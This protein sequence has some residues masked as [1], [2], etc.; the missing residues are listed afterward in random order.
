MEAK[1]ASNREVALL[2]SKGWF[3]SLTTLSC[4]F[5]GSTLGKLLAK[6]TTTTLGPGTAAADTVKQSQKVVPKKRSGGGG[7]WRAFCRHRANGQKF[8]AHLLGQFG[9]EWRALGPQ[10]RAFYEQVGQAAT[11]A[12]KAG[13]SSFPRERSQQQS[14]ISDQLNNSNLVNVQPQLRVGDVLANGAIVAGH[15][16]W[17]LP[18]YQMGFDGDSFQLQYN[19]VKNLAKEERDAHVKQLQLT[20]AEN[21]ALRVYEESSQ[22]DP[23]IKNM[24]AQNIT[25]TASG[26]SRVGSVISSLVCFEWA[27]PI[28]KAVQAGN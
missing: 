25:E 3:T 9:E 14:R 27:P 6:S 23:F 8:T 15:A 12:H 10:E 26:F 5:I 18:P 24:I 4:S 19:Y 17:E 7:G 16:D 2:R 21:Q 11:R 20:T 28:S 22:E 1:H 13:Y